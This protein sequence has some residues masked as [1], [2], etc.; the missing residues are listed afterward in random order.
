MTTVY[1][2]YG[3]FECL[4]L[5]LLCLA[6]LGV[7]WTMPGVVLATTVGCLG[8]AVVRSFGATGIHTITAVILLALLAAWLYSRPLADSL[9]AASCTVLVLVV[10]EFTTMMTARLFVD[11]IADRYLLLLAGTPHVILLFGVALLIRARNLA[12]FHRRRSSRDALDHQ[13][14]LPAFRIRVI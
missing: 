2:L 6:L 9:A 3:W 4:A 1:L 11:I 7:A 10:L 14:P 5:V 12:V 8:I 13:V